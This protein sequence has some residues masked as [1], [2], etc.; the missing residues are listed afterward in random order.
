MPA[1]LSETAAQTSSWIPGAICA[2]VL[3]GVGVLMLARSG[4]LPVPVKGIVRS[5]SIVALLVAGA[6][7]MLGWQGMGWMALALVTLMALLIVVG[8]T[9]FLAA[10]AQRLAAARTGAT[11]RG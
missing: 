7:F 11:R 3:A 10:R 8:G 9:G 5:M 4:V 6:L 2:A 1:L